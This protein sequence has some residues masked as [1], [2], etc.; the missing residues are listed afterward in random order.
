MTHDPSAPRPTLSPSASAPAHAAIDAALSNGLAQGAGAGGGWVIGPDP[1]AQLEHLLGLPA[2]RRIEAL[3]QFADGAAAIGDAALKAK[4]ATAVLELIEGWAGNPKQRLQLGVALS[5]V[6]DPRLRLPTEADYWATVTT[7]EGA[8]LQVG[9]F[10]VTNA[11]LRA[12]FDAGGDKDDACW[13]EE[14]L[15]WR[16][17]GPPSWAALAADPAVRH[18]VEDNQPA[19]G[20][21]WWEA[22]AY[23]RASGA[24]LPT[25]DEYRA[26]VRGLEKRPYPW[27]SPFGDGNAN[28]REEALG[29][30]CA[31]GIY[32]ADRTPE[33]VCDL[34][35]NMG[36]WLADDSGDRKM[37][38]PGS[39]AR[40]SM[41]AW[42]KAVDMAD[43]DTRSADMSFRLVRGG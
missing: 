43:P 30:P 14:G 35:G 28:T 42:A 4:V 8:V 19:A 23:A 39:W 13:S 6:G 22:E 40:P 37:L 31:V 36:H 26:V 5:R 32:L 7:D 15:A 18:L 34:A 10:L 12:W 33:G 11:E 41:A 3:V 25:V 38:H 27:G 16:D 2:G 1:H 20:P 24:R 29:Q 17:S 21:S 9:R